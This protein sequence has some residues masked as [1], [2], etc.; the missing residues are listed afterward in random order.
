MHKEFG[1]LFDRFI[2]ALHYADSQVYIGPFEFDFDDVS[3]KLCVRDTDTDESF[4]I[5]YFSE[6]DFDDPESLAKIINEFIIKRLPDKIAKWNVA[7][8]L[9]A[10]LNDA[11]NCRLFTPREVC[12]FHANPPTFSQSR[13]FLNESLIINADEKEFFAEK[14]R[15]ELN[16]TAFLDSYE[17]YSLVFNLIRQGYRSFTFEWLDNLDEI[18]NNQDYKNA[19][20]WY[21]KQW[22]EQPSNK[23]NYTLYIDNFICRIERS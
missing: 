17:F 10:L 19:V 1:Y 22:N 21:V 7:I 11:F 4:F 18:E 13:F 14:N 5:G 6:D 8:Y 9:S 16:D 3:S 20:Y 23:L 15:H 12:C 2:S